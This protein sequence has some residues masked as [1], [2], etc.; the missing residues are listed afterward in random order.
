MADSEANTVS[1]DCAGV[2]A[3]DLEERLRSVEAETQVILMNLDPSFSGVGA[4]LEIGAKLLVPG[5][6]GHF[7]C[8][9][10]QDVDWE[11]KGNAGDN[12]GHSLASGRVLVSGSARHF[13]GAF[14]TGGFVVVLGRSGKCTAYGMEGGEVLVRS[15]SGD[16]AGSR[17]S[18]GV[19]V[20]A[21]GTGH[22]LGEGMTGGSIYLRGE[23]ASLAQDVKKGRMKDADSLR[24][25]LLLARAGI[26]GDVKEFHLYVPRKPVASKSA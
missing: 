20:L 24:L 3:I 5:N 11:I 14:A 2:S 18:G 12:C 21:N 26:Q 10:G 15:V 16:R 23:A 19:L 7:A 1:V 25:S 13:A 8:M 9:M 6:I 4:G 22:Q 17:M